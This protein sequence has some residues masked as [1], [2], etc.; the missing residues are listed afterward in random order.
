VP[1]SAGMV[2]REVAR[3]AGGY[4]DLPHC[5]DLD[6]LLRCLE[7]GS[8]V[9]NPTVGV[10][11]HVHP[12]QISRHRD[13]MQEAHARVC[14]AYSDRP[15]WSEARLERWRAVEAWD[16][17]QAGRRSRGAVRAGPALL[18]E[19]VAHPQRPVGLVGLWAARL[20]ARR[21][22][23]RLGRNGRP[24]LALL[25]R[26]AGVPDGWAGARV[27]DLRDRSRLTALATLA[28]QPT[29]LAV[30]STRLEAGAARLLGITPVRTP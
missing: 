25:G 10:I 20:R 23:A 4:R 15:W 7:H 21:R 30:V 14:S 1:A 29:A 27:V 22:S 18:K 12:E 17:F 2:R 19:L 24:S 13:S 11:Y 28:R 6:F 5:A 8:G 9:V 26:E 3:Q 16:R